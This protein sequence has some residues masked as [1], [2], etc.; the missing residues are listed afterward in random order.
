VS[1]TFI[2]QRYPVYYRTNSHLDLVCI[3]DG[4]KTATE[5]VLNTDP[6]AG[7]SKALID[8]LPLAQLSPAAKR[9]AGR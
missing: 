2:R 5:A 9:G 6:R 3:A 8:S 7:I 1:V 4:E